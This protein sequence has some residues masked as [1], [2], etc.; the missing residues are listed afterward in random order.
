MTQIGSANHNAKL[1]EGNVI[2]IR[3]AYAR[4]KHLPVNSK[5]RVTMS[6]LAMHYGVSKDTIRNCIHKRY[7]KHVKVTRED[8]SD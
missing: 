4:T 1:T 7:W 6:W 3:R 5:A 8:A 2:A